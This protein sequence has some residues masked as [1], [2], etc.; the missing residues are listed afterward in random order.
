MDSLR[1][2]SKKGQAVG[3]NNASSAAFLVLIIAVLI[4]VYILFLPA[5]D[6]EALL[7]SDTVPGTTP[8]SS[9]SYTHL[10]G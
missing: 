7:G 1:I 8:G 5:A 3:T 2:F 4:V 6:R 9:D 10:V